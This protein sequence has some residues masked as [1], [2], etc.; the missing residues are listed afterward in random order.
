MYLARSLSWKGKTCDMVGAIPGDAVMH[1]RPQGR[2]YVRLQTTENLPWPLDQTT[3]EIAAH[4]FHYS[5]LENLQP[6]AEYA[7]KV[8]RGTGID[9]HNDG[10]I[11][12]NLLACYTHQRT[13][14]SNRWTEHFTSFVAACARE[15]AK[16]TVK[17]TQFK[18]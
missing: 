15:R 10:Y 4:E 11:Y 5:A 6:P 17:N 8:L 14:R 12:K 7:F 16:N 18:G 9:G 2:G 13:T 3:R 1:A